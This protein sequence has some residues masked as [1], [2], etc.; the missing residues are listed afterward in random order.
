MS[1]LFDFSDELKL[2]TEQDDIIREVARGESVQVNSVAGSGKTTTLR[3]TFKVINN[4]FLALAFNVKIK[5]D[6]ESIIPGHGEAL[7]MNGLGHRMWGEQIGKRLVPDGLKM[8]KLAKEINIPSADR[9][10]AVALANGAKNIGLTLKDN[11]VKNTVVA[12]SDNLWRLVTDNVVTDKD[13][14]LA[15]KLLKASVDVAFNGWVDFNDQLYM[16]VLYGTIKKAYMSV[17]V[18]EAQDLSPLDHFLISKIKHP[19][20]Q[21]VTVGDKNQ[22]IYAFRGADEDSMDNLKARFGLKEMPMT[23]SFRC[24]HNIIREAQKLVPRIR[25][26]PTNPKGFVSHDDHIDVDHITNDTAFLARTNAEVASIAI[27]LMGNKLNVTIAGKE[28]STALTALIMNHCPNN[29]DINN[30]LD[31]LEKW[32]DNEKRRARFMGQEDKVEE[33]DDK[34][35]TI[36]TMA[37]GAQDR[38]ELISNMKEMFK[39]KKD[40]I[41]VSTLHRAKGLEWKT[42]YLVNPNFVGRFGKADPGKKQQELNLKYVGITRAIEN[43]R[44]VTCKL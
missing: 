11:R 13:I 39:A 26:F 34:F 17:L 19:D 5:N 32:A 10:T 29:T 41:V 24:G 23:Y 3:E 44:L 6:L 37:H 7:T 2:T 18:D 21:L 22:S 30:T 31:K 15:R 14:T 9:G 43:L 36:V 35:N 8:F 1:D 27:K 12:D 33:I 40:A 28:V 25:A 38:D 16:S 20:G 4:P 42:V